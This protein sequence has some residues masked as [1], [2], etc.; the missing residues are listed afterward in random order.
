MKKL[1]INKFLT[2]KVSSLDQNQ[3]RHIL[4]GQNTTWHTINKAGTVTGSGTDTI[5]ADK[6]TSYSD[7]SSP[8]DDTNLWLG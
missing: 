1:S 4:G 7:N 8:K 3:M 5:G 2:S 6:M